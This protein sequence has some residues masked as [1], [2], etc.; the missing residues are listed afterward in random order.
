MPIIVSKTNPKNTKI[1]C[2]IR[3]ESKINP[4]STQPTGERAAFADGAKN[5]SSRKKVTITEYNRRMKKIETKKFRPMNIPIDEIN[6]AVKDGRLI[7]NTTYDFEFIQLLNE[8]YYND[9][10]SYF[11]EEYFNTTAKLR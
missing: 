4:N 2:Q 7:I 8:Q 5:G 11:T 1:P 9:L 10:L 3:P 6:K